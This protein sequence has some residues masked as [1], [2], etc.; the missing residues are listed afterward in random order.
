[1][2][3]ATASFSPKDIYISTL[4]GYYEGLNA[5]VTSYVD[6]ASVNWR[7]DII[8]P[9]C[10]ATIDGGARVWWCYDFNTRIPGKLSIEEQCETL[11]NLETKMQPADSQ[12]TMGF[13]FDGFHLSTDADVEHMKKIARDIK[14]KVLT[15]HY[16]GG[17]WT[18]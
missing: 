11:Q 15:T 10:E 9:S 14:A 3:Q 8:T 13:A 16:L 2:G 12:V 18:I 1:M 4:E 7:G 6:H 17:P 5:G